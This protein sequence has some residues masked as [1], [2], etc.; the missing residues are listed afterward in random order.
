MLAAVSGLAGARLAVVPHPGTARLRGPTADL[1][2][3]AAAVTDPEDALQITENDHRFL[4]S[5]PRFWDASSAARS[6]ADIG[7]ISGIC[8]HQPEMAPNPAR[9]PR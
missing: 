7:G 6:A 9:P 3:A 5:R 2:P 1:G 8:S 4:L